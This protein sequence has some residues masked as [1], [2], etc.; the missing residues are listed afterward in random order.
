MADVRLT[1]R[2]HNEPHEISLPEK[3]TIQDLSTAVAERLHVPPSNQ[4]FIVTPKIGLLRPPFKDPSLPIQSLLDRKIILLGATEAEVATLDSAL[5]TQRAQ[6]QRREETLAKGRRVLAYRHIDS[7]RAQDEARYTFHAIKPLPYLP[8]PEKS[9]RFLERLRDDPGIKA[10]MRKHGFQVGLLTEMDPVEHT[11]H[12]S[13]TLG[14]NRNRGEMIELRLRT[15]RYDGYRDYKVIR[16]TLCHELAHNVHGEHDRKFWDLCKLIEKEVERND[17]TRGG[18][19]IGGDEFF[20]PNDEGHEH[21]DE[22]GWTGRTLGGENETLSR[23]T[24]ARA[25]EGRMGKKS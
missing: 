12:Q 15:D 11:T 19:S 2:W 17:W 23:E 13:R 10:S 16:N 20:N 5:A 14:L 7:A 9:R 4:K 25:A 8:H 21:V 18:R 1:L 6:A 3:S 24:L 22:G